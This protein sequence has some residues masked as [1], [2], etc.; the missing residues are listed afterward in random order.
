MAEGDAAREAHLPDASARISATAS[1][2]SPTFYD[3]RHVLVLGP[4]H[5]RPGR[6]RHRR[7]R[8]RGARRRVPGAGA[9]GLRSTCPTSTTSVTA[10]RSPPPACPP[11]PGDRDEPLP[12]LRR[13]ARAA[14][15]RRQA[16][17]ARRL[18]AA[19]R[20]RARAA[21]APRGADLLAAS[22]RR[23]HHRRAGAA[24]AA[25]SRDA[26]RQR[27]GH[28]GQQQGAPGRRAGTSCAPPATISASSWSQTGAGRAGEGQRHDA[29]RTIRRT[30]RRRST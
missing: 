30:G 26:R 12:S 1:R 17:S 27:R 4:R 2:T 13:R 5:L 19:R 22:G 20:A 11:S 7:R 18:R 6:R 10:R 21:D 14:G 29:A 3:L 15:A 25:R 23:V 16:V 28:A 8:A 24:A 9:R